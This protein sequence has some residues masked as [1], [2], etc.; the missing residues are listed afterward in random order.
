MLD[1]VNSPRDMRRERQG[2]SACGQ[3]QKAGK[4]G[5]VIGRLAGGIA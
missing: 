1:V 4:W 5:K 3:M 2:S